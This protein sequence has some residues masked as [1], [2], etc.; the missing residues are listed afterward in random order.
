MLAETLYILG[1]RPEDD[2]WETDGR[3]TY[4]H[5]ENATRAFLITLNG[6]LSRQGWKREQ[7]TLRGFRHPNGEVIEVES[8]GSDCT[9]HY[10]HYMKAE[11]AN[12][13]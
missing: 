1:Y 10:L 3:Q 4:L 2:S 12:V 6:I 11:A 7:N 5:E 9:G 8:G 13:S